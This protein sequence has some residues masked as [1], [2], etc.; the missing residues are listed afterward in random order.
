VVPDRVD[1]DGDEPRLSTPARAAL[2]VAAL[3]VVIAVFAAGAAGLIVAVSA[4]AVV[5]GLVA[6]LRIP[7]A[8]PRRPALRPG[9]PVDNAPYRSYRA[10]LEALSWAEVSPRHYD[11]VTRP[12]FTRLLASRLADR[13]RVD[14]AADPGAARAL[15]GEDVWPYLD[16]DR[17]VDHRGQPPGLSLDTLTLIV[18][19]LETL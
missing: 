17:E 18:D 13:H 16:P 2:G 9:P 12:V 5:A 11:L 14:L 7:S 4:V 10:V 19:R 3:V 8:P 15:V 1:P 6:L